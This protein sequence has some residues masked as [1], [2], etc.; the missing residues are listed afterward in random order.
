MKYSKPDFYDDFRC[1]AGECPDTCCA[2]WQIAIDEEALEKYERVNG[3]FG[4]RLY[5]CID[6]EESVFVQRRGV[7]ALLNEEGLCR[8]YQELGE[9]SMCST[10]RDYPRHVEEFLL[11]R[12][13]S[14]GLSCPEAARL[15]LHRDAPLRFSEEITEEADDLQEEFEDFD[16]TLYSCLTEA[17]EVVWRILRDRNR[18]FGERMNEV[19]VLSQGLQECLDDGRAEEMKEVLL[20]AFDADAQETRYEKMRRTFAAFREMETLRDDWPGLLKKTWNILYGNGEESYNRLRCEFEASWGSDGPRGDEWSR[21]TENLMVYFIYI[22]FCGAVYDGWIYSKTAL[23]CF[24]V[25]WIQE[26]VMADWAQRRE[27]DSGDRIAAD[28][29]R[30]MENLDSFATMTYRF[31]RQLEHSDWNLDAL[32]EWLQENGF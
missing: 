3:E 16:G 4:R 2:G 25:S 15:L 26:M 6:W 19:L 29:S 21:A 10:C 28:L 18:P 23:A 11:V 27:L 22:Y 32:E 8:L 1:L 7:C 17:R 5:G 20:K 24:C 12:E 13:M 30:E 9:G 31:T 14:L